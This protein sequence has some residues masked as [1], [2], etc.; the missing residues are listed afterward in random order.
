MN[1]IGE[2]KTTVYESNNIFKEN[3]KAESINLLKLNTTCRTFMSW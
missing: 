1:L 2:Q 3:T